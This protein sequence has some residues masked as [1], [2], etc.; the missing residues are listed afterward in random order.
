[1]KK[2]LLD[3]S[4]V[5]YYR[6]T[7]S[8]MLPELRSR[9]NRGACFK[10]GGKPDDAGNDDNDDDGDETEKLTK[11]IETR[12]KK[13]LQGRATVAQIEEIQSQLVFLTKGQNEKGEDIDAPFPI[14]A[15]R[16]MADPKSGVMKKL[17]DMGVEIQEMKAKADKE[18]KDMSVRAQVAAWQE[19]N[20][21]DI[22]KI[23]AG[24]RNITL[25]QLQ[26]RA[27]ASPMTVATVNSGSSPYI[28]R[29]EVEAGINDIL[30]LPNTLWNTIQKGRTSASTYVWV[31]KS[32]RQGAAA[33]IGPGVAK[34]GVSFTLVAE[35]SVAKKI[36]DSAKAVT[37]LL[38]DIDGMTTFIEQ[39]LKVQVYLKL[40]AAVMADTASSTDIDGLQTVSQPFSFYTGAVATLRTTNPNN[41]DAVRSAV[42]ALKSGVLIGDVTVFM[43][44]LDI[45]NMDMA[46]ATDSGV[47]LIPPFTTSDGKTISGARI[48]EDNNVAIGYIEAAMLRYY[49]ILIY[50]DFFV[51]W[52]W[53]ND[54]FTKN[55]VTAIGEVRLHQF[56]N[57]IH[58]G[59][60]L[61]DTLANIKTAI[62]QA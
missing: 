61:Y 45:A 37:E 28:G 52:G 59:F 11:K 3:F 46:K 6:P 32:N 18:V 55:M 24:Q 26:I 7:Q 50:K 58:T 17:V 8:G 29:V 2:K 27:A 9:H 42:A 40:N 13:L 31:N 15:L 49:R 56:V 60:A 35:S 34:P 43:N 47:Y 53:E 30:V 38:Q 10:S 22:A 23:V 51:E 14:T 33:F 4:K 62:T 1:M 41:M 19:K 12:V 5:R 25:P 44:S 57:S 21:D 39:E 54:D 36:A 20:K 48:I 16:E